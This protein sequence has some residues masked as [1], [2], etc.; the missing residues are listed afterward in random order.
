MCYCNT[1][2]ESLATALWWAEV[3]EV[4]SG[5]SNMLPNPPDPNPVPV[6][7]VCL[8]GCYRSNQKLSSMDLANPAIAEEGD[9]PVSVTGDWIAFSLKCLFPQ[10]PLRRSEGLVAGPR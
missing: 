2:M 7:F 6:C 4:K 5:A 9:F 1:H 3:T 8:V 10:R